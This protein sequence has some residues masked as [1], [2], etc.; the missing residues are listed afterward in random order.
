M[1]QKI[2]YYFNGLKIEV[3]P[4]LTETKYRFKP[5]DR[6]IIELILPLND[7]EVARNTVNQYIERLSLN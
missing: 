1:K 4:L 7:S 3:K 5:N 6:E 2:F